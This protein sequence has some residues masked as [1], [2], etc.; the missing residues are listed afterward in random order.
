[1]AKESVLAGTT[2][3]SVN[4]FIQDSSST[5]G[6]GLSGLVFN[7][8]GL[9]ASYTFTGANATR[10]AITL[11]TLAAVNSAFSS[12]GFKEIDA[13]NMKGGYR[14]D[15][16]NAALAAASGQTVTFELHGATNMAPCWFEIE[17]TAT[18]NQDGV[19]G[20]MTALPNAAAGASGGGIINGSNSGTVTLAA[21][22]VTGSLTVSDGLLISRS[23]SN[24]SA[25]TATGNGTGSGAVF[26][27]GAGATGDG[28]QATAGS[29]N[30]NGMALTKT[31]S[32]V[33]LK[34]ATTDMA[35]ASVTAR[36][37][38]NTDQIAGSANA[39]S[40]LARGTLA[41]VLGTVGS[42]SSTTSIVT[43]AL[44]PAAAAIDQ[45]KGRI[46]TF[47]RATTTANLRGQATDI[48]GNTALGVLTVTALTDAPVSGDTFT[49]T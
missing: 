24:T 40:N 26:T 9:V 6:A 45:F 33:A 41:T 23:S 15:V 10:V 1:M 31:G 5:V 25:I 14:L 36:V 44:D 30:G 8:S 16:P 19:R 20:G 46:V 32:G 38:A 22:T 27:S 3:H 2:S 12:G 34:G 35:V 11:A 42:A 49:I 28:V 29:T 4:I 21:L 37:T 18:N 13:T 39:A 7:T 17:L 47:D 43:S 48:T